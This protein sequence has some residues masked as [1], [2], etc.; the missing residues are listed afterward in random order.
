MNKV[1]QSI[2]LFLV[3]GIYLAVLLVTAWGWI[4]W[5]VRPYPRT[6][7]SI[8][9]LVGFTFATA[10]VGLAISSGIY[11]HEIGGFPFYDPLLMQIFRTGFLLSVTGILFSVIG[12]WRPNPFRWHAGVC[13][14]GTL[15]FWLMSGLGE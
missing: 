5:A 10:S 2:I 14:I 1:T 11:A 7:F 8:M 12:A 9:S 15:V 13:A 3:G 4:R 6:W